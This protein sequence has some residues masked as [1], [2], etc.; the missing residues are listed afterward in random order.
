MNHKAE[1]FESENIKTEHQDI[2]ITQVYVWLIASDNKIIIVSKNGEKWQFPGGHPKDGE[3]I[4]ETA[5]REAYEETG[6]DISTRVQAL[7]IFG[8]YRIEE[9][10][11][12]GVLNKVFLQVRTYLRLDC[13]SSQLAL[14][15]QESPEE[16]NGIKFV[17]SVSMEEA[18]K[19]IPWLKTKEEYVCLDGKGI[20]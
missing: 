14:V 9:Y 10:T 18:F 8:Y 1:W 3:Q 15:P 11:E 12:D 13:D 2:E 5:I 20:L 7:T 4:E 16:Q 17:Q 19:L 6:Q